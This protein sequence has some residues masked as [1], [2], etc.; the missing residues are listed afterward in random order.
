VAEKCGYAFDYEATLNGET[1]AVMKRL[2]P[3]T[4]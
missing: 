3:A 2:M 1:T 4:A